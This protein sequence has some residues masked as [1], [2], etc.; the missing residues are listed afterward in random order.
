M[1]WA[2]YRTN[3]VKKTV[4]NER[5]LHTFLVAL[6]SSSITAADRRPRPIHA[7]AA[8]AEE[9]IVVE[10]VLLHGGTT[11]SED[12]SRSAFDRHNNGAVIW[13]CKDAAPE[14]IRVFLPAKRVRLIVSDWEMS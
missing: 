6:P 11:S 10:L 3:R 8:T 12:S 4:L 2:S 13:R 14:A 7:S 1:N 5:L 9:E